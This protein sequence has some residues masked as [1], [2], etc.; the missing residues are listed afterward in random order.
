MTTDESPEG[1][2]IGEVARRT[3][4]PPT[5]IRFYEKIFGFYIRSDRTAGGHRRYR[6]DSIR[7]LLYLK[8][9][10]HTK[11]LSIRD[12]HQRL[13]KEEDPQ[14]LRQEVKALHETIE[15]LTREVVLLKQAIEQLN[16]RIM[17]LENERHGK[18]GLFGKGR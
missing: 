16:E 11:G 3:G 10:L 1:L 9:L 5:T 14:A 13:L 8:Y 12:V 6:P 18:K 7:R 4:L 17:V 15:A 2:P